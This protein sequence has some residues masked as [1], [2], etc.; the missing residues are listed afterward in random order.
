MCAR[1]FFNTFAQNHAKFLFYCYATVNVCLV[2]VVTKLLRQEIR[3]DR[4][5]DGIMWQAFL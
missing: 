2:L 4:S 5:T 3:Y 1:P